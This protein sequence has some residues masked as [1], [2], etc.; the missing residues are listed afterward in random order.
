[1]SSFRVANEQMG[2]EYRDVWST[3]YVNDLPDSSF[4]YIAPGG[5]KDSEGKT[6]PRSL[7]YFPVKD[8]NGKP[9]AAHI[10]N[11]LARIPQASSIPAAARAAAMEKAKK[12]A[13]AHPEIGS[14]SGSGYEGSAGSGRS[15]LPAEVMGLQVRSFDLALEVR[16]DG[17]GRTLVGRAVPYGQT[18]D[19][20]GG[21][22]ERFVPG[23]FAKQIAHARGGGGFG[24][25][26]LYTSHGDRERGGL[27]A[28]KTV[29]LAEQ[30]DGLHGSWRLF[31][32]QAGN[33]ALTHVREGD[34]LGLSIGFKATDGGTRRGADGALER[35]AVHLDH[36]ALTD[37][38]VYSQAAVMSVRSQQHP[39]AGYRTSLLQARSLLDRVLT[40]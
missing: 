10:R 7:R 8:A 29:E 35:H 24:G 20:G 31:D 4:L 36:V 18:A 12:M 19:I 16:S 14:G 17:D 21:N 39:I 32:T 40:G 1:M 6:T 28:G 5:T 25:V 33:D 34:M 23:A 30:M 38:P 27:A 11:A 15:R 3:A 9:D 37:A 2:M 22:R 13:A 26:K